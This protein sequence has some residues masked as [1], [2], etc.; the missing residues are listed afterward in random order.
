MIRKVT[1]IVIYAKDVAACVAFYEETLGFEVVLREPT[2]SALKMDGQGFA[3]VPLGDSVQLMD[4]LPDSFEAS[5]GK[6]NRLM[7]CAEVEDVDAT[8]EAFKAKGVEF[9]KAPSDQAWGIR[10]ACFRDPEGNVW[11]LTQT[12]VS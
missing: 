3:I 4:T 8:Y 7:L 5:T 9:T 11:E 6:I 12:I 10:T 2:M 1:A